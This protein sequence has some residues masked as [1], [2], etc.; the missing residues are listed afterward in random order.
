V[1]RGEHALGEVEPDGR[2]PGGGKVAAEV[3][4]AAR[5]VEHAGRRGKPERGDRRAAPAT[6]EAER[7][8]AVHTVVAGRDAVEHL[9]DRAPLVVA[10]GKR[11]VAPEDARRDGHGVTVSG[12]GP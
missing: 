3:A 7:D 2:M 1:V 5:E 9:L 4:G 11:A 12:S 6:I 8:H 10:L